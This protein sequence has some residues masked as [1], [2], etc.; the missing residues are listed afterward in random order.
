VTRLGRRTVVVLGVL[1]A[2]VVL[3]GLLTVVGSE[4]VLDAILDANPTGLVV[5]LG[6]AVAWLAAWSLMLRT[7][8]AGLG[9]TVSVGTGFLLTTGA[10]FAN[11]V[12]PF[13]QAGGEPLSA[14]V[15][16]RVLGEDYETGLVGIVSFDATNVLPSVALAVV[17]VVAYAS[18]GRVVDPVEN[19]LVLA[20]VLVLAVTTLI[21]ITWRSRA[22]VVESVPAAVGRVAA[23]VGRG[24][25]D[26]GAV[27]DGLET[28][29]GRVFENVERVADDPRRLAT[30]VG[31]S[32]T[33]W[34]LQSVALLAAFA[35][36][37]HTVTFAVCLFAVPLAYL[38]GAA[39][40][41]GGLGSI[42]AAFVA[43]LA[44]TTGVPLPAITASVL[45][46]RGVVYW[47]PTLVGGGSLLVLRL[48]T[49]E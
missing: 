36:V 2:T 48:T 6:C 44:P 24:R 40:L 41:P 49:A 28:R 29:L 42:E 16:S 15:I 5:A 14:Y 32:A 30:V 19:S 26:A 37:G 47:F 7:I 1:G 43:L 17:G 31:L 34:L 8:L 39:P 33:G 20:V 18:T 13:G 25:Y 9:V 27:A 23:A 21:G 35:A 11:N 10:V 4:R 22:V 12:T 38:A 45:V 3:A 46:F